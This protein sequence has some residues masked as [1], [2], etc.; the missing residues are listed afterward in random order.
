MKV[1]FD[2][3]LLLSCFSGVNWCCCSHRYSFQ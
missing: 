3:P 1:V 2:G